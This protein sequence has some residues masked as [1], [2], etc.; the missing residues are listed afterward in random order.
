MFVS[1]ISQIYQQNE[2]YVK[3]KSNFMTLKKFQHSTLP[4]RDQERESQQNL[5]KT[6]II[7]E[8][9]IQLTELCK[10]ASHK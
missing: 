8:N 9:K 5:R 7:N 10:Y 4:R 6:K 2:H 1:L 3:K